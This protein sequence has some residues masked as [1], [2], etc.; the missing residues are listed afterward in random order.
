[1]NEMSTSE[2]HQD[3]PKTEDFTDWRL[4]YKRFEELGKQ[5]Y[6]AG[7][8]NH[9]FKQGVYVVT[10]YRPG[11]FWGTETKPYFR[12]DMG[13]Y[14]VRFTRVAVP[15]IV[16][17]VRSD[18]YEV[19]SS[20]VN[21]AKVYAEGMGLGVQGPMFFP[22][23]QLTRSARILIRGPATELARYSGDLNNILRDAKARGAEF[24][25]RLDRLMELV[26]HATSLRRR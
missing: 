1:M 17:V 22:T 21:Q 7:L 2:W 23:T 18:N 9:P 20:T 19:L 14:G 10:Y 25:V 6:T 3:K 16:V 8:G 13:L 26:G 12:P 11:W 15:A 4:A 5:G 24:D